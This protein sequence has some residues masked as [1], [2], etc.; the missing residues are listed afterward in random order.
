MAIHICDISKC[1]DQFE[2]ANNLIPHFNSISYS[3]DCSDFTHPDNLRFDISYAFNA[4]GFRCDEFMNSA[5]VLYL[6]CSITEGVGLKQ[7]DTWASQVHSRLFQ[8]EPFYNLGKAANSI[9]ANIRHAL[10]LIET[11]K[12][13]PNYIFFFVPAIFRYELMTDLGIFNYVPNR[14]NKNKNVG[15]QNIVSTYEAFITPRH[16]VF[17]ILGKLRMFN[18]LMESLGITLILS[19]W[20]NSN[21]VDITTEK[22]I[23]ADDKLKRKYIAVDHKLSVFKSNTYFDDLNT[24]ARDGI[25]PGI[26][27][28]TA[29]ADV[30][31]TGFKNIRVVQG[32]G[33]PD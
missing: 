5:S 28:H 30:F 8:N 27:Y 20:N 2:S 4:H 1:W 7:S 32:I 15:F 19:T 9:D 22:I 18:F 33:R 24:Y 14:P 12:I 23:L 31:V 26:N 17:D 3:T 25:H 10:I 13:K 11:F 29:V 21:N 6:G 16:K